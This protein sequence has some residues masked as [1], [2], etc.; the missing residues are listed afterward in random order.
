M[1]QTK[2][3]IY[4]LLFFN[5]RTV[6]SPRKGAFLYN[7]ETSNYKVLN[8]NHSEKTSSRPPNIDETNTAYP[9]KV[10]YCKYER[11]ALAKTCAHALTHTFCHR[12]LVEGRMFALTV[13]WLNWVF[14]SSWQSIID[15]FS[16]FHRKIRLCSKVT[17]KSVSW[18]T[19]ISMKRRQREM[20]DMN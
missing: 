14:L 12:Y 4:I 10:W 20:L 18:L 8:T 1:W 3:S 11:S 13:V 15:E 9:H 16:P 7:N 2:F 5:S 17:E 19:F 6:V